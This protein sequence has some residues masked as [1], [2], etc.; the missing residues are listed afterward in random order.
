MDEYDCDYD[1]E[2]LLLQA[3]RVDGEVNVVDGVGGVGGAADSSSTIVL[4]AQQTSAL[5]EYERQ[6]EQRERRDLCLGQES[7]AL[8]RAVAESEHCHEEAAER[9]RRADERKAEEERPRG[10]GKS[11]PGVAGSGS[12][13]GAE[14]RPRGTSPEDEADPERRSECGIVGLRGVHVHQPAVSSVVFAV[15]SA[16]TVDGADVR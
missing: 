12:C 1:Q 8:A 4:L 13:G 16:G 7:E 5:A 2:Q 10:A 14:P 11:D 15:S 3:G 6:K 9:R